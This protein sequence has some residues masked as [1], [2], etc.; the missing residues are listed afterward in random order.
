[1][2]LCKHGKSAPL[3]NY[4]T[5]FPYIYIYI[6][7][8]VKDTNARAWLALEDLKPRAFPRL[9]LTTAV[10]F[11]V[12]TNLMRDQVF[13]SVLSENSTFS[14]SLALLW[15]VSQCFPHGFFCTRVCCCDMVSRFYIVFLTQSMICFR[16]VVIE[17]LHW[18]CDIPLH[19]ATS[20]CSWNI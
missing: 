19:D 18:F 5:V 8:L 10:A 7:W 20:A 3:L 14:R 2:R 6:Y 15:R 9:F 16:K 11:H 13:P 1:M 12:L 4:A 17:L